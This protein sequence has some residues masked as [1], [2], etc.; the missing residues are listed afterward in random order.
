MRGPC[1]FPPQDFF[2]VYVDRT[3]RTTTSFPSQYVICRSYLLEPR[4]SNSGGKVTSIRRVR[5]V[6]ADE[7]VV[8]SEASA[9]DL[10]VCTK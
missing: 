3:V 5:M 4:P 9:D 10:G 6:Y 7:F 2:T 1:L 8:S